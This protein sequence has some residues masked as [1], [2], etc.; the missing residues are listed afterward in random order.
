MVGA[1]IALDHGVGVGLEGGGALRDADKEREVWVEHLTRH[2]LRMVTQ[3][4][5][6]RHLQFLTRDKA[7]MQRMTGPL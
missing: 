5:R 6:V 2:D 3:D 1:P 4:A 7:R